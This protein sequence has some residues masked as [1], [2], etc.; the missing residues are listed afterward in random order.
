MSCPAGKLPNQFPRIGP[1]SHYIYVNIWIYFLCC[2][3]NASQWFRPFTLCNIL[4]SVYILSRLYNKA[5]RAIILQWALTSTTKS[6]P[7]HVIFK[8]LMHTCMHDC[9]DYSLHS[10]SWL[11]VKTFRQNYNFVT[12]KSC[13]SSQSFFKN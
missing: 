3:D 4:E 8:Q 5:R 7:P 13:R 9:M 6:R 10:N 12:L 1:L 2:V 11:K